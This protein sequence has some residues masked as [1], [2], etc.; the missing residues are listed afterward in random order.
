MWGQPS[1]GVVTIGRGLG[2]TGRNRVRF[3]VKDTQSPRPCVGP[4]AV[5]CHV[6]LVPRTPA[7]ADGDSVQASL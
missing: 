4:G 1:R 3:V 6:S 7:V 5:P 2:L